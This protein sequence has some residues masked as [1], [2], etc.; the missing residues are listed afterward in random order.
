MLYFPTFNGVRT[1]VYQVVRIHKDVQPLRS[2]TINNYI[3][4][5]EPHPFK[6]GYTSSAGRVFTSISPEGDITVQ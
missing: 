4:D 5:F 3:L 2:N 1:V 6:L